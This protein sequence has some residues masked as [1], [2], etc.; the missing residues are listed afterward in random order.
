MSLCWWLVK[1]RQEGDQRTT[2]PVKQIITSPLCNLHQ[3]LSSS[4]SVPLDTSSSISSE[5]L[6]V[7]S[8]S[9]LLK[10]S[11]LFGIGV[12]VQDEVVGDSA[13]VV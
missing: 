9:G 5:D 12:P 3:C 8:S 13:I 6:T 11:R 1:R 4:T 7:P 2:G 10:L